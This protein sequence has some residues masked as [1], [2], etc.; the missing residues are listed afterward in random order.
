MKTN[1]RIEDAVV[2]GLAILER[3][4]VILTKTF[5]G[6]VEKYLRAVQ[7]GLGDIKGIRVSVLR[8]YDSC[9]VLTTLQVPEQTVD[10]ARLPMTDN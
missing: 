3:G 6:F 9:D 5:R 7:Q 10:H 2:R 8:D 1:V 4:I